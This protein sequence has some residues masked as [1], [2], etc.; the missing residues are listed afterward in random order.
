MGTLKRRVLIQALGP[1]LAGLPKGVIS[2][3]ESKSVKF[4]LEPGSVRTGVSRFA[5]GRVE[6]SPLQE[7]VQTPREESGRPEPKVSVH[8]VVTPGYRVLG[9]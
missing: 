8:V 9:I 3:E 2:P 6:C 5:H 1:P 7:E 4:L